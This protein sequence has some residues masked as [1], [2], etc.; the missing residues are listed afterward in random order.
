MSVLGSR[1]N[2]GVTGAWHGADACVSTV[3]VQCGDVLSVTAGSPVCMG[4]GSYGALNC[5]LTGLGLQWC[6]LGGAQGSVRQCCPVRTCYR[7]VS[8]R[9]LHL[10]T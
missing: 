8:L 1:P 9:A 7:L 5:H 10:P 3:G 2:H 4:S 6:P